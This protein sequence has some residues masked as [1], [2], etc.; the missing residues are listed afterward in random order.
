MRWV[1][2]YDSHH[3][4]IGTRYTAAPA[5]QEG[6]RADAVLADKACYSNGLR[7]QI[8]E[9]EAQAVIPSAIASSSSH[10]TQL[11]KQRNRIER[12]FGRLMHFGRFA[13]R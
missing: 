9:V 1:S 11:Y 8:A 6:H 4:R 2:H 10:D 13:T 12:C 7:E 3:L 5:L